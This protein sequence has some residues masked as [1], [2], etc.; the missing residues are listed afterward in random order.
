MF[1]LTGIWMWTTT[2]A[3]DA[4]LLVFGTDSSKSTELSDLV[5]KNAS[6]QSAIAAFVKGDL[7]EC[8]RLLTEASKNSTDLPAVN[9]MI[10][11]LLM[12]NGKYSEALTRLE[13]Y[14]MKGT[15]DAEAHA[16]L[17]EIAYLSGRYSDAWLQFREAFTIVNDPSTK[18]SQARK[19]A[20]ITQLLRLRAQT[21]EQRQDIESAEKL[22][23]ELEKNL[24]KAGFPLVAQARI[25]ISR[26]E[27]S[28]GAELL[29][30]ARKLDETV[31]QPELQI[32]LMLAQNEKNYAE[33]EKWFQDGIKAT[34]TV[35]NLNWAEYMKWLLTKGRAKEVR[36]FFQKAPA[37]FQSDRLLRFLDALALRCLGK[38]D[39]AEKNFLVLHRE[40]TDDIDTSDQL[41]LIW[42]E[43]N[44]PS[45]KKKAQEMS[46]AN[47]R[48]AQEDENAI[49][50]VG[51]VE[52]KLGRLD[53]AE[54]YFG[55]LT[56]RGTGSPQTIYYVACLLEARN[57]KDE[58]IILYKKALELPGLFV[59]R[60]EIAKLYDGNKKPAAKDSLSPAK[61]AAPK[62]KA[63]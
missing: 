6:A 30:R 40:N 34:E 14:L 60:D 56:A 33:T 41:A 15:K 43:S 1:A 44:D 48:R 25:L 32:A 62:E 55:K 18:Y 57:R 17:G 47:L 39:E 51:W 49:A 24:P 37:K 54:K 38:A 36:F 53:E 20:F 45:K 8:E 13:F 2:T 23:K 16:T 11:R 58:A 9:V 50:T 4:D 27:T 26:S 5:S 52:L 31:P 59:Q 10:S 28:K 63:K 35:T 19:D 22:Y 21:A 7:L 42:A 61:A 46:Q 12:A 29:R 3:A